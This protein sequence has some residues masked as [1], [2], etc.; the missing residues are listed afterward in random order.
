M[1]KIKLSDIQEELTK[2]GWKV[3]SEEYC[4]LDSEM[5]FECDEG[6]RV[7]SSWKK[8][9]T[10]P[11][12][13]I[14]QNN[15][16]KN[17]EQKIPQKK[18]DD[19]VVLALDQATYVTGWSVYINKK[20]VRYG[21]FE[22]DKEDEIVRDYEIKTWLIN[23]IENFKPDIIGL[24]GIQYQQYAGVTTFATLA[25]LQGILMETIY[26]LKIPYVICPTGTWRHHCGVKGKTR[27]DMK[28]SMQ[29]LAKQWYEVS[30]TSDEADAVGIG[31]FVSDTNSSKI[32][33][34]EWT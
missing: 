22:V 3:I 6:H 28:R 1:A 26:E 21:T 29:L 9:R 13:P 27:A 34:E 17:Q 16:L 24:E 5:V 25:R 32:Q 18:K 31:K 8:I 7:Y 15:K 33:L 11:K 30:I 10:N 20:L 19:Y 12:C 14:C 23:M 2:V 4:N